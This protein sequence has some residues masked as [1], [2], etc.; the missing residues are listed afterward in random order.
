MAASL[1]GCEP[2]SMGTSTGEDTADWEDLVHAVL[3]CR[4]CELVIALQLLVVMIYKCSIN[5]LSIQTPSIVTH[6]WDNNLILTFLNI[7]HCGFFHTKKPPIHEALIL[8]TSS[9]RTSTFSITVITF[10]SHST[11]FS[12]PPTLSSYLTFVWEPLVSKIPQNKQLY[13]LWQGMSHAK[14]QPTSFSH[15]CCWWAVLKDG[16]AMW[17]ENV[18][19]SHVLSQIISDIKNNKFKQEDSEF[20]DVQ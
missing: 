20:L 13:M 11:D 3:N 19:M 16:Q 5:P 8:F 1:R 18:E 9:L 14:S 6:T 7:T 4:V 10:F 2:G 12:L 17:V 15:K